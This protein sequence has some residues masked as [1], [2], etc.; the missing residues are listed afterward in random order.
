MSIADSGADRIGAALAP[1]L[2]KQC[3]GF[4]I[5]SA[6]FALGSAPGFGQWAGAAASNIC[7]FIGAWFFTTAGL[8]QLLRS[9]DRTA[10]VTYGTGRMVRAE[11]LTAASQS[12]GTVLF[13]VSTTAAIAAHS[14]P[15]QRHLVWSPDAG[16]S[17]A[18]L[19]SGAVAYIAYCRATGTNWA[20]RR[21]DWWSVQI[22]WIGCVAFGV[23]A[24][25]AYITPDGVPVD[26]TVATVGTFIGAL[27]FFFASLV[28][29]P[30]RRTP[31][32]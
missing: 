12:L 22:N 8:I 17:L 20:P 16:G 21:A 10:P 9:G 29:L 14:I 1:T 30:R 32:A 7:Y 24:V 13:N 5:G 2:R 25:G 23:S 27:C 15:S 26:A 11:W 28:V 18:F 31:S 3:W 19:V 4:M 6:L